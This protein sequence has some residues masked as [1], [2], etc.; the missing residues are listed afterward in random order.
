MR[1]KEVDQIGDSGHCKVYARSVIIRI[2][3]DRLI[4]LCRGYLSTATY[5]DR[6]LSFV[7]WVVR[8]ADGAIIANDEE[9]RIE[10][11]VARLWSVDAVLA[12]IRVQ[13]DLVLH[14]SEYNQIIDPNISLFKPY[15]PVL[16][17]PSVTIRGDM[18]PD[19]QLVNLDIDTMA[20]VYL[21]KEADGVLILMQN[22]STQYCIGQLSTDC[23]SIVEVSP[24]DMPPIINLTRRYSYS[25]RITEYT[26][27]HDNHQRLVKLVKQHSSDSRVPSNQLI[28][29]LN[30]I[31]LWKG[32]DGILILVNDIQHYLGR[33]GSDCKSVLQLSKNDINLNMPV[34]GMN[35]RA[36]C[37]EQ[38][39]SADLA[40]I[41]RANVS[42]PGDYDELPIRPEQVPHYQLVSLCIDRCV[43][44][45]KSVYLWKGA[46]GILLIEILGVQYY[47]G[48]LSLDCRSVFPLSMY[49]L[50]LDYAI[51]IASSRSTTIISKLLNSLDDDYHR[52]LVKLMGRSDPNYIP[53]ITE[54]IVEI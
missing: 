42:N 22:S 8:V 15:N 30:S 3:M 9:I 1:I 26:R 34:L 49:D 33:L 44:K 54:E 40:E 20:L 24:R 14:K 25:R 13:L 17:K 7:E 21:W 50:N 45:L 23:R 10:F 41:V 37:S 52:R 6:S 28:Q 16:F 47:L 27:N 31:Y 53:S 29:L 2:N 48:K 4:S 51:S 18:I 39:T 46:N 43:K 5:R 36:A 19:D 35:S 12:D 32:T 11:L 38:L